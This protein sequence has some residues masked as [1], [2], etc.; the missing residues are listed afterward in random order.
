MVR[1]ILVPLDGSALGEHALPFAL[2]LARRSGAQLHLAHVHMPPRPGF[3]DTN[4][5]ELRATEGMC[6]DGLVERLRSHW[7]VPITT[8]LLDGPIA[9]TLHDYAV[10]SQADLIVMTTHGRG[11]L[12]RFWLGCIA[13]TLMRRVSMPVLLIRPHEQ[14]LDLTHESAVKH[15]LIPLDG[16]ALAEQMLA[17]ATAL[18]R[19]MGAEYTLLQA[20]EPLVTAYGTELY[21]V[22]LDDQAMELLRTNA[23]RYLDR[24]A[25]QLRAEELGV[26]TAIVMDQAATAILDYAQAH[27]IDLLALET[28]GRSGLRWL[29]G[30]VADKILRGATMPVLLH[31]PEDG[32]V[33]MP[34]EPVSDR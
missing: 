34:Q 2:S 28:H 5:A 3:A 21:T 27:A 1:S 20:I 10:A 13:D 14:M 9:Q 30:G 4:D 11:A 15:I 19:L 23:Q 25:D 31:R 12:S 26:Q 32:Q 24:I 16:S 22:A 29:V 8:L 17:R 6:V 7:D 18:G 33:W